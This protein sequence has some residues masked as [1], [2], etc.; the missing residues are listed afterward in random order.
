MRISYFVDS[1]PLVSE[2]FAL[3]QV[4]GMIQRGHEVTIFANKI[5]DQGV[6]HP[7]LERHNLM[8]KVIARPTVPTNRLK[9][10]RKGISALAAAAAAGR[11]GPAL[12][13]LNIFRFGIGALG[14]HLLIRA[15]AHFRHGNFDVLHCQFGQLG[16][17]VADLRCCGVLKGV[18]TT[19]FRGADATRVASRK[20][21]KFQ[22]LF[23]AG[24]RFLAVSASIRDLLLEVGC[25]A[26]KI[27][28]L[29]SGID[30][31]TFSYRGPRKLNSPIR[32]L[33]IGR[34]GP[35]KGHEYALDA[36]RTLVDSG[37][38]VEYRIVGD[39]KRLK[40]LSE[41]AA[42]RDLD[43]VVTFDGAVNSDAVVQILRDTDVLIAPSVVTPTGQTEGVPNVLKEAMASGVPVIGTKVGGVAELIDHGRNGFLVPQKDADAIADSVRTIIA[44]QETMPQILT[45]AR[46]S[47][48]QAYDV[49]QLN[50]DLE[51]IYLNSIEVH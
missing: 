9:R 25:P 51:N 42:E 16:I 36:V 34:L 1:F 43:R 37:L 8:D 11:I 13:T 23:A 12:A 41:Y 35:T 48:E 15:G 6:R 29:R 44:K 50:A 22:T 26:E 32:L 47:I 45:A 14:M 19:S 30:L 24:D 39:G 33:T 20:P 10:L 21:E 2:T 7:V 28:I 46:Q 27:T 3:A 49:R 4:A 18:L 40:E 17:E 5:V 31:S 38:S